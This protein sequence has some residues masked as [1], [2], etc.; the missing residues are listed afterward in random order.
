MKAVTSFLAA[1][2]REQVR[3]RV[4][5]ATPYR[6]FSRA[7]AMRTLDSAPQLALVVNLLKNQ[8][9][10]RLAYYAALAALA[11]MAILHTCGSLSDYFSRA[12]RRLVAWDYARRYILHLDQHRCAL[13]PAMHMLKPYH[14]DLRACLMVATAYRCLLMRLRGSAY[15]LTCMSNTRCHAP[16]AA[17]ALLA[18]RCR[19]SP[20]P[21][22]PRTATRGRVVM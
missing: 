22:S 6:A 17:T 7:A 3:R 19:P 12:I 2:P 13:G 4:R 15:R 8:P 20:R 10:R 21:R 16:H 14:C 18:T 9:S 1:G 11:R 5:T